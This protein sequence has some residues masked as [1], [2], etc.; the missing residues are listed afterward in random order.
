MKTVSGIFHSRSAAESALSRLRILGLREDQFS[1][2]TP[3]KESTATKTVPTTDGEQPGMGKVIGG[4]VGG[5]LGLSGGMPLGAALSSLLFPG[6][7]PVLAVGFI[8]AAI[9]GTLGVAGG[10]AAG[11]A[12]EDS[13]T[14]GLPRD[15][16]YF[17]QHALQQDRTILI[18]RS[19]EEEQLEVAR[20]I[21]TDAGAESIDAARD[22]WWIGLRDAEAAAYDSAEDFMKVESTYRKGFEAALDLPNRSKTYA[23]AENYLTMHY[24]KMWQAREFRAGYERGHQYAQSPIAQREK[25]SGANP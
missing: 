19:D 25:S 8:T 3:D 2:L 15:E 4:V 24:P 16:L 9:A 14:D 5:A 21:L 6:V 17:Y 23:E 11:G 22:K 13:L 20:K 12:L 1:L 7:G 10:A 18:V